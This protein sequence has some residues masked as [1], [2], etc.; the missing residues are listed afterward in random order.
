[1]ATN[2]FFEARGEPVDG[3]LAVRDVTNNRGKD[4][5]A[6]VFKRKQFSWTHQV[7]WS[8]IES[9]LLGKPTLKDKE[10]KAWIKAQW[11]ATSPITVLSEEYTHYHAVYVK[12]AWSKPGKRIG[13]HVFLKGVK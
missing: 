8:R 11:V 10:Y 12:P 6:V 1:M 9:F 3:Q 4:T 7:Q 2:I 5:C 13:K